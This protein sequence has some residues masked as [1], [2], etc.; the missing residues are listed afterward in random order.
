MRCKALYLSACA[1][2]DAESPCNDIDLA[3]DVLKRAR[4]ELNAYAPKEDGGGGG[5]GGLDILSPQ[6]R[7]LLDAQ[8]KDIEKLMRKCSDSRKRQQAAGKKRWSAAFEK[9]KQD[10]EA[11]LPPPKP[12]LLSPMDA[13]EQARL[14][15]AFMNEG[16]KM[17]DGTVLG[18]SG[19]MGGG[20]GGGGM[21]ASPLV[22]EVKSSSSSNKTKPSNTKTAAQGKQNDVEEEHEEEHEEDTITEHVLGAVA[23]AGVAAVVGFGLMWLKNRR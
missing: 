14:E 3:L 9:N 10:P 5:G 2:A 8:K 22:S 7:K 4:N 15:Q 6:V 19:L 18:G 12:S 11:G 17:P 23:L 1:Y 21:K 20:G 16:I 13:A